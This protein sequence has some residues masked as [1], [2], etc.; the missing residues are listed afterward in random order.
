MN[1]LK[2]S[3]NKITKTNKH[4]K[5]PRLLPVLRL[6]LGV[7]LLAFSTLTIGYKKTGLAEEVSQYTWTQA[8]D[9]YNMTGDY[10]FWS[11]IASSS[12]GTKLAAVT[13][14]GS[15]YTSTDSGA[16]WTEQMAAGSRDWSSIASS[17]DGTK[18]AAAVDG[19]SIYTSTD[20]GATW[21]EQTAAGSRDW[22]SIASSSDGT[23][24]AAV[25][26]HSSIYTSTDSGATWTERT[27]AGE[28]Y[29][30]SIA[31]SSDGTKLTAVT[32]Y[33][34]SIYT[35]TDS[36]ATWTEQT[37]AGSRYWSSIASSSDGTKLAAAVEGGSIYT[38]TDSG[39]TWTER[40]DAGERYWEYIT[41]SSDGTKLAAAPD[42]GYIYTSTDSGA[43]WTERTDAGN[44]EWRYVASSNDG[45]K[46]TAVTAYGGSIYT[47]TDSGATWTESSF[48]DDDIMYAFASPVYA[49]TK[50]IVSGA[51]LTDVGQAMPLYR[52][53]I[54][55]S[56]DSGQTWEETSES[57]LP[58]YTIL[59][60]VTSSADGSKLVGV[61]INMFCS[62]G[63][64]YTG[65][66]GAS[67]GDPS[68]SNPEEESGTNNVSNMLSPKSSVEK[69]SQKP[70]VLTTPEDTTITSSSTL[71]ESELSTQDTEYQYPIGLVDFTMTTDEFNNQVSLTFVTDLKPEEVVARKYNPDTKQFSNLSNYTNVSVTSTTVDNKQGLVLSYSLTDNGDLDLDKVLGVIKDPIGLA[72]SN[73]VYSQLGDTGINTRLITVGAIIGLAGSIVATRLYKSRRVYRSR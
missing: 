1:I 28:R 33:G 62:C 66:L 61:S 46:L 49:G 35:S 10:M 59:M 23:K 18:L 15:I 21:T 70:V 13:V 53:L 69:Y 44:R 47:S 16:T 20:S 17:S 73:D 57:S 12:D 68:P 48:G 60:P 30:K 52:N 32:A 2:Q 54:M 65:V 6:S 3:R 25:V 64:I 24:L 67:S 34:G 11:S 4:T 71:P 42:E 63:N 5:H 22:Q 51:R 9:K 8:T 56:T 58:D 14:T 7:F 29:W 19:G 41:S 36:G 72:V 43:T 26:E 37:A 31:S 40:T 27:D 55:V 38:S 50:L 45:T 39:A